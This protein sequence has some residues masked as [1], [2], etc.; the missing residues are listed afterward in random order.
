MTEAK[1][2]SMYKDNERRDRKKENSSARDDDRLFHSMTES[3]C[4]RE[5]LLASTRPASGHL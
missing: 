4:P 5:S 2:K 1:E 3:K